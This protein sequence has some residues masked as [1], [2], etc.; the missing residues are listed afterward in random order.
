[1]HHD[2]NLTNILFED[3]IVRGVVDWDDAG[4][5]C[6][7]LDVTT[8][9]F[10]WHRLRIGGSDVPLGGGERLVGRIVDIAT[11]QGLRST[12]TYG[13]VARLALTSRRGDR[14]EFAVWRGVVGAIVHRLA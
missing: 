6:R 7:A 9:L 1:V 2:Y 8:L 5:G 3:G 14:A 4:R 10:E 11:E 13:A 12:V